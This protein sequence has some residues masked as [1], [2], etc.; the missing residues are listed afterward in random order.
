VTLKDGPKANND[1]A[2][3]SILTTRVPHGVKG[4]SLLL[5]RW[6]AHRA[7]GSSISSTAISA[8]HNLRLPNPRVCDFIKKSA[9]STETKTRRAAEKPRVWPDLRSLSSPAAVSRKPQNRRRNIYTAD[10]S[11]QLD[12]KHFY[13]QLSRVLKFGY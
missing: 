4:C 2:K 3:V 13:A 12:R 1:R 11:I 8:P 6:S 5:H 7:R 9:K 10:T